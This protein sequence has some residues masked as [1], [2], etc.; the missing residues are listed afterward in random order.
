MNLL[1]AKHKFEKDYEGHDDI[2]ADADFGDQ[3]VH[4]VESEVFGK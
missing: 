3:T 1:R 2:S 4:K